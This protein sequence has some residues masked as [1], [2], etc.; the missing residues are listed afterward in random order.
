MITA[1]PFT[2]WNEVV[3]KLPNA[4]LH[5]FERS[6]HQTFFEEPAQFAEVVL[7]WM[8]RSAGATRQ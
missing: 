7:A 3:E 6:G 5:L 2:M 1:A 4:M 8:A